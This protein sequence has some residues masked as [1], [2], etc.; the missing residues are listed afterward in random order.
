[1]SHSLKALALGALRAD[2]INLAFSPE[3]RENLF[4][5]KRQWPGTGRQKNS[6]IAEYGEIPL[7]LAPICPGGQ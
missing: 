2:F 3:V 5:L 7:V 1:M 4:I 6:N